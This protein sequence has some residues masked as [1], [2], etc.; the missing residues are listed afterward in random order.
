[1]SPLN[2]GKALQRKKVG[3]ISDGKKITRQIKESNQ[4]DKEP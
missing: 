4:D 1:M 3:K 2:N